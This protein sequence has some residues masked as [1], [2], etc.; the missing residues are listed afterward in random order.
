MRHIFITLF[1]L[2]SLTTFSQT[3][4]SSKINTVK[5]FKK[6]AE[7]QRETSANLHSGNQE[8]VLTNISPYINPNSLQVQLTNGN[9]VTLLSAK[10]QRNYLI[11]KKDNPEIEQLKITL[12]TKRDEL[13]W[14]ND[15][16][17]IYKG[18]EEILGANKDLGG[19]N[20]S[21]TPTQVINLVNSYKEKQLE[22]KKELIK[23]TKQELVI[24]K[25]YTQ[26][27]NQLNELNSASSSSPTGNIVLQ[28]TSKK[29]TNTKIKFTYIVSNAGWTPLYDLRSNG[30]E[31]NVQ[32]KYKANV[33]QST[34]IDWKDADL[35]ISTGNPVQNNDRPILSPLYASV[36]VP[37][38]PIM[39]DESDNLE[40][41]VAS[42][43]EGQMNMLSKSSSK[44]IEEKF[45]DGYN[46]N[47]QV[48]ENQLS[49]EFKIQNKQTIKSDGK[50]QILPLESYE[51][52]TEYVYHT[53]PKKDKG[54]YLLAKISN[55]GK[56]NLVS[57]AA[58]LFFEG[59]YVGKSYINTNVTSEELFLSLGRDNNINVS[60]ES[61]QEYTSS[62]FVGSNKK[63]TFGYEITVKNKKNIKIDIE[64]LDQIPVSRN[65]SIEVELLEKSNAEFDAEIGKLL[66]KLT[67]NPGASKTVKL[68]Y[69]VKYP[70]KETV[71]GIK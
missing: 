19:G 60:R 41:I 27:Q 10:Y 71:T 58:N 26:T 70:K 13:L 57:G 38:P 30:I 37:A 14:I 64:I 20:A 66:W 6:N 22:I 45:D 31:N 47:T 7:I 67:L 34:N 28:L 17:A 46:Y 8:I 39:Y 25:E 9:D 5:V 23:L 69:S 44:R 61:L 40:E 53:V 55:W 33:F 54:V 42:P 62:K 21:F 11:E 49:T 36:Y 1:M 29:A 50:E 16:R 48:D 2:A 51:L 65:K 12:E 15:Q 18:M 43:I 63:E 52:D 35:T 4:V 32:L 24:N 56:Y 59:A 3:L 68:N